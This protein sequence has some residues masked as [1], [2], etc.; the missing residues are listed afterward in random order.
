MPMY[1]PFIM[2]E[3]GF[4]TMLD[5]SVCMTSPRPCGMTSASS[6]LGQQEHLREET[7]VTTLSAAATNLVSM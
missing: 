3:M 1:L 2:A 6:G 7:L 5:S 4:E